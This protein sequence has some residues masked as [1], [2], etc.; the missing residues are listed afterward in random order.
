MDYFKKVLFNKVNNDDIRYRK[1]TF[2][3]SLKIAVL[4]VAA[5]VFFDNPA[6][7]VN[8]TIFPLQEAIR[9]NLRPPIIMLGGIILGPLWGAVIGGVI[10]IIAFN[11]WHSNLSYLFI[12]TL[13]TIFRGFTAGYIYN[14]IFKNFSVKA[15]FASLAIPHLL[16]SGL[17]IPAILNY[18]YNIPLLRNLRVRIVVQ[19]ITLPIFTLA[20]YYLLKGLKKTKELRSLHQK[21]KVM[22]NK[23]DLTGISN[24]KHFMEFLNKIFSMAKRHSQPL[25]L[26]MA[27][28]DNFKEI[29]D[30]YGHFKGDE[31]LREV[32][33]I[34]T[35]NIRNEDLAARMGGDEFVVL[36]PQTQIKEA[37]KIA[38]RIKKN[39]QAIDI[40][41]SG[42]ITISIGAAVIRQEDD[43]ESFLKRADDA[44]YK[45]KN[46]GRN[47]IEWMKA[48]SFKQELKFS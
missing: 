4:I 2:S 35:E 21:L 23:D 26:L 10:D 29:N 3:F 45:A 14:Y 40:K 33:K 30:T 17:I 25:S 11:L 15:I 39:V 16:T 43:I 42:S 5:G 13:S 38:N 46:N 44:L 19:I 34:L 20:F 6:N 9:V 36:L 48:D 7:T 18:Y 1:F 32:A 27:D 31:C 41:E 47:R 24:R 28:L 22:L 37:K 12:L 8:F